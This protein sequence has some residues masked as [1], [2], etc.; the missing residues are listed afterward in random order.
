MATPKIGDKVAIIL[1]KTSSEGIPSVVGHKVNTIGKVLGQGSHTHPHKVETMEGEPL[2][3]K[4][5]RHNA[6][7]WVASRLL[8]V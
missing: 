8:K 7:D 2:D 4:V 1:I 3:V 6:A 5:C